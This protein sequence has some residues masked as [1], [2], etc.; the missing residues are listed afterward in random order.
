[1]INEPPNIGELAQC[2]WCKKMVPVDPRIFLD[3]GIE[4]DHECS[5]DTCGCADGCGGKAEL[6]PEDWESVKA[7]HHLTEDQMKELMEKGK[8]ERVETVCFQCQDSAF[9][10]DPDTEG[11]EWKNS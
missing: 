1:M 8:V 3:G 9:S 7:A 4:M 5:D 11:E 10:E 6:S 2:D